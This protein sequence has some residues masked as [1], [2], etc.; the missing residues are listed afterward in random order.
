VFEAQQLFDI[1]AEVCGDIRRRLSRRAAGMAAYPTSAAS[2]STTSQ[3]HP[4][5]RN[6]VRSYAA[7]ASMTKA[8]ETPCAPPKV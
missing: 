7:I 6:A 8:S 2:A 4:G 1:T 3:T 5:F